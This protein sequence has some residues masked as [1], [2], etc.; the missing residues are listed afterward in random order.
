LHLQ[1]KAEGKSDLAKSHVTPQHRK[2]VLE[3]S[4]QLKMACSAHA[5]V[6][7]NTSRFYGWLESDKV[8]ATLPVGPDVWICG[9]CHTGNLGPVADL[10]GNIDI[11]IRDLDQTVIGNPAHDLLRLGLSLAMAVRSSDLPGV[12]TALMIEE[13]ITGYLTG[14]GGRNAKANAKEIE[15]IRRVMRSRRIAN[16]VILHE[17]ALKM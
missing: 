14:L 12:T 4:Q 13:M 15:P 11:Q 17:S 7:G 5:Y 8:K 2:A 3:R 6:R 10:E 9:D 16:G 1:V